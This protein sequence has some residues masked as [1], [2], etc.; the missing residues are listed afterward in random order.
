MVIGSSS[1]INSIDFASLP[2]IIVNNQPI[3][4]VHLFKNLGVHI[5]STLS[6]KPHVDHFLKKVFSSLGS[7][8][9]YRKS[10]STSLRTQLIKSLV[11][12]HFDYASIVFIG[13]DKSRTLELHTAHNSCIRFIFGNIPFI[14]TSNVNTH[15]THKRPTWLALLN[16]PKILPARLPHLQ[17]NLKQ[18]S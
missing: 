6:W 9:F 2:S 14:P 16:K 11:L 5:T 10:L 8:K 7:L 4:Y 17:D 18:Q 12:P 1:Y 15:L 13:L 3:E